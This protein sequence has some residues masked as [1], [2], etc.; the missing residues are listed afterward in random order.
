MFNAFADTFTFE[1]IISVLNV[2][3]LITFYES[4]LIKNIKKIIS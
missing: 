1:E 4:Y 3:T 2:R